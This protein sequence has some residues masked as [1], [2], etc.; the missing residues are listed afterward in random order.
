MDYTGTAGPVKVSLLNLN[1]LKLYYA[2]GIPSTLAY[3]QRFR[4]AGEKIIYR[5]E[6]YLFSSARNYYD[7]PANPQLLKAGLKI[8]HSVLQSSL[9]TDFAWN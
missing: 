8:L 9:E 1:N 4:R 5:K 6:D 2:D 3:S 7:L